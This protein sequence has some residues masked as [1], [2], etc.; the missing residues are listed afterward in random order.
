MLQ[1]EY[2]KE[3][4]RSSLISDFNIVQNFKSSLDNKTN[5]I[6]HLFTKFKSELNFEKFNKSVLDIKLE[7]VSNDTYLKIFDSNIH[8]SVLKPD[9]YDILKSE[10][11]LT[12]ENE[13][14]NLETGLISYENLQ[15]KNND[16]Y[17]YTLPYYDFSSNFLLDNYG[18]I[19]LSSVGNNNLSNT[20]NLKSSIINDLNFTSNNNINENFG[21]K[22]NLNIYFK[23][24]NTYGKNDTKYKDSVQS[25]LM[26]MFE[27]ISE[28]P[29]IKRESEL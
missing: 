18:S 3:F 15:K 19:E 27:I 11:N 17:E 9:N 26:G 2:R 8:Q 20:N 10:I 12:L 5:S 23:N 4:R 24:L 28:M 25:Q 1:S 16:R 14:Y 29:L 13:K 22:N 7:K 21:F 6:T